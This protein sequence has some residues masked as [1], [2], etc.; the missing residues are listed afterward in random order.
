[1]PSKKAVEYN[2]E[3]IASGKFTGEMIATLVGAWQQWKG[4]PADEMCGPATQASIIGP[5]PK[6]SPNDIVKDPQFS[7]IAQRVPGVRDPKKDGK[8][9]K[10]YGFMIH[11]T[12]GQVTKNAKAQK[13]SPLDVA[14][15]IYINSQ[16]GVNM[17]FWGGPTYV[18]DH[19]GNIWQMAPDNILTNHCGKQGTR[20]VY[21]TVDGVKEPTWHKK[22]SAATA[23]QWALRWG[24]LGFNDPTDLYPSTSPNVDYIGLEIIPCG[25][26]F[27]TPMRPGLRFTK[28]QHDSV[29][30][31]AVDLAKRH[32]WK[33]G[34]EK[35]SM[36][37][38]HEDVQPMDRHD[39]KGGWDIGILRAEPFFDLAYV[40]VGIA[41]NS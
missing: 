7:Y 12:G 6:P 36:F 15:E 10:P 37:A 24:P 34:W 11:T 16:N 22:V 19:D 26:G 21:K 20:A 39:S 18:M 1:M 35:T 4:L 33:T 32:G 8:I 23:I 29:V 31:L 17:Y 3:Q 14:T 2:A 28:A 40:Q 5:A 38:S 13:K 27:G 41:L 30:R 25:D 9:R